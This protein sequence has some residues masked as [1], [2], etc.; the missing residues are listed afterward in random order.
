MKNT[1]LYSSETKFFHLQNGQCVPC[2]PG[3]S[4]LVRRRHLICAACQ[5]AQWV[6]PGLS[7]LLGVAGLQL[8]VGVWLGASSPRPMRSN[9]QATHLLLTKGLI[10]PKHSAHCCAPL[11][12]AWAGLGV[13]T[14][15]IWGTACGGGGGALALPNSL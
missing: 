6:S 3:T 7:A 9:C 11:H 5:R 13:S 14:V 4:G 15:W 2:L 12:P 1:S 10:V 8:V